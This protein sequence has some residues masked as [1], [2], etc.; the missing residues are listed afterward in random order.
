MVY[1][2]VSCP[3]CGSDNVVLYGKNSGGKQRL[4]C[5][6]KE[7]PCKT[8]Q[9]EY[10]YNACKPGVRQQIVDMAQNGSGT[11]DTGRALKVS[12]DTVTSVLKKRKISPCRSTRATSKSLTLASRAT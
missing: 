7:C 9:L 11:R 4:L 12:K 10:A 2:K 6:N 5:R 3:Q 8:F 1:I